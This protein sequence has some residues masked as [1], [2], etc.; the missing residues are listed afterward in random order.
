MNWIQKNIGAYAP[1]VVQK[2]D[3]LSLHIDMSTISASRKIFIL[4]FVKEYKKNRP[5]LI[6]F[7][8]FVIKYL[9][10]RGNKLGFFTVPLFNSSQT[11]VNMNSFHV[12]HSLSSQ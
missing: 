2:L 8:L 9:S 10:M 1:P 3:S 11:H 7:I 4:K 5:C 6:Y 12:G